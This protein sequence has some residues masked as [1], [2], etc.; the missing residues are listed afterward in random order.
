MVWPP[1]LMIVFQ[2]SAI[3]YTAGPDF[4][5][6]ILIFLVSGQQNGNARDDFRNQ[7]AKDT[8]V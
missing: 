3:I 4:S 8:A 1:F 2:K 7:Q 5:N 6:P